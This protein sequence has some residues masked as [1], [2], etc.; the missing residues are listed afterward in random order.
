MSELVGFPRFPLNAAVAKSFLPPGW[1]RNRV[2]YMPVLCLVVGLLLTRFDWGRNQEYFLLNQLIKLRHLNP[3]QADPRLF[4]VGIDD[5]TQTQFGRWPFARVFHG[6]FLGFLSAA[7]PAAVAWDVLFTEEDSVNDEAFI[8]G[9]QMAG[10]PVITASARAKAGTGNALPGANFGITMPLPNVVGGETVPAVEAVL[11]PVEPLRTVSTFGFTDSSPEIDG[12]RRKVPLVLKIG[13]KFYPNLALQTLMQFWKLEPSQLRVVPGDAIYIESPQVRRRI[14]ID[15]QGGFLINYRYEVDGVANWSYGR[16]H[17]A[18]SEKYNNRLANDLPDLNGKIVMVGLAATGSSEIGLSPLSARSLIPLVH[19]NVIDNILRG[20]YL[21]KGRA[22]MLWL[23]WLVVAYV[24]VWLLERLHFGVLTVVLPSMVAAALA[25]TY[26]LFVWANLWVPMAIPL[27][28]FVLLHIGTTGSRVLQEQAAR[29]QIK[30]TFSSYLSPAVL[31]HVLAK[32]D[33]LT[34]GGERKEV[35]IL[36]SDIRGFTSMSET[37]E[38]DE[39]IGHLDE[40]FTEM[41]ECVNHHGGTLHKFIGDAI[42]AV[43]GDVISEGPEIDARNAV[44]AALE[45]RKALARLNEK[46]LSE[47]RQLFRIGIGLNQGRVLVGNIGAPQRMEFTVIGDTVNAASRIEGMTKEWHTDI[48]VGENVQALLREQFVFRTLG[49]FRLMGKRIALR[50]Y[51]V[52][53]EVSPERNPPDWL[54]IY[55]TAFADYVAGDF[56]GAASGFEQVL[57]AEPGDHCADHYAK[58]CRRHSESAPPDAWDAVHI[59]QRK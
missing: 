58:I 50:I 25:L 48:A 38:E 17:H 5:A 10:A 1:W 26:A 44:R 30:R 56:N 32:A 2:L 3:A 51:A 31:D 55:E 57:S 15:P 49:L 34:L 29:R 6:E 16:L 20:D 42:M 45:M 4:F 41:V 40:Y 8:D 7:H 35:T 19:V 24:S 37:M 13:G 23:G 36:F 43:W 22:W 54:P 33:E 14:P 27:F 46:W 11:I 59:S 52:L 53:D 9:I 28:A 39:I 12:V 18:L 47:G 21:R